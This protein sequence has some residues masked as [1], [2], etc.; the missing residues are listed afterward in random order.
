[1]KNSKIVSLVII[2]VIIIITGIGLSL[3]EESVVE[4]EEEN[5]ENWHASGPISIDKPVY[6]IGEKVFV[7]VENI[8]STDKGEAVFLRPIGDDA[9]KKYLGIKFDGEKYANF[10]YY[11]EPK[12]HPMKKICSTDE[13]VGTWIIKLEGTE[14]ED[15]TFEIR[16]QISDWD[17]RSYEPVC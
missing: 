7:N 3:V 5:I 2:G 1:M 16:N 10:N 4:N 17:V 8:K 11:F 12:T 14:Y 15:L 6:N 9:Y 13:L